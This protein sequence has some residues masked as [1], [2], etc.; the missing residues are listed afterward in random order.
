[1]PSIFS[2][3]PLR[4]ATGVAGFGVPS[5]GGSWIAGPRGHIVVA[6]AEAGRGITG[7]VLSSST[8][9]WAPSASAIRLRMMVARLPGPASGSLAGGGNVASRLPVVTK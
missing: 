1:M 6:D 9:T 5:M 7:K 2:G 3:G 8:R 4:A